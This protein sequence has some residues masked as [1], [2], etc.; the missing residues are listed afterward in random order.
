[1]TQGT[2]DETVDSMSLAKIDAIINA[3]RQERYRWKPVRR[4]YIPKRNSQK[5][6]ALGLPCAGYLGYPPGK[7]RVNLFSCQVL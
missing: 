6:R 4:V 3:L 1:M 7:L 2:T 5:K